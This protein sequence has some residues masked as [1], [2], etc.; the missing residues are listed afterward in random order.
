MRLRTDSASGA[1]RLRRHR[2]EATPSGYRLHFP[3]DATIAAGLADLA[4]REVECC[5]FFTFSVTLTHAE[6]VPDRVGA[7]RETHEMIGE[8]APLVND[9]R[10]ISPYGGT[11][12]WCGG[13]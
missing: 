4:A 8:R 3:A 10:K 11:C 7:Y 6:L 13:G 9:G 5:A 1:L 12:A 2:R